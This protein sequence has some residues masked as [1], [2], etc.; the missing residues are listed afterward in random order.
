MVPWPAAVLNYAFLTV[1]VAGAGVVLANVAV[2]PRRRL[3]AFLAMLLVSSAYVA[4][5][6]PTAVESRFG[7]TIDLLLA[8]FAVLGGSR[9]VA[10]AGRGGRV[11]PWI[12]ALLA[13]ITAAAWLSAWMQRQAPMLTSAETVVERTCGTA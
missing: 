8:P 4:V 1:A 6:A 11:L 9:F 2:W 5:Y 10:A 12:L 3:S 13:C 7:L